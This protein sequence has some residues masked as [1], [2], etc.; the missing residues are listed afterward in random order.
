LFNAKSKAGDY[1][2]S[3]PKSQS[4]AVRNIRAY[5]KAFEPPMTLNKLSVEAD[6]DKSY[7]S[8]L[9]H[10]HKRMHLEHIDTISKALSVAPSA[11]LKPRSK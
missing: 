11:L 4:I 7:L 1:D 10:G 2:C 5:M 3:M 8:K 9:L 6:I